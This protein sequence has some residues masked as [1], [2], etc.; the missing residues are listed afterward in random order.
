[1]NIP[2]AEFMAWCVV[3]AEAGGAVLLLVGLFVRWATIPMLVT[4]GVVIFLV[5][6]DN[7]WTREANGI[8]MAVTY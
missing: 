3:I 5:H 2:L 1:M 8:E 4:M 6:W 7:G